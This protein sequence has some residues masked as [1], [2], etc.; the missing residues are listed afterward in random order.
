MTGRV[1]RL[2]GQTQAPRK[3]AKQQPGREVGPALHSCVLFG[4]HRN[5]GCFWPFV[6]FYFH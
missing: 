6:L 5:L 4:L 2:V 3:G 1:D